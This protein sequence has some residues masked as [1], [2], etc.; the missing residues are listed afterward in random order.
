VISGKDKDKVW[1]FLLQGIDILK[2]RIRC[3]LI[4]VFVNSLLGW[5]N[6]YKLSQRG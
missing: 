4:P 2:N 6:P 3:P 5:N 1:P